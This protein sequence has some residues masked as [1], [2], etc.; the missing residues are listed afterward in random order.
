MP[1]IWMERVS[2]V[3]VSEPDCPGS[4]FCGTLQRQQKRGGGGKG[5]VHTFP[6]GQS[7]SA[8]SVIQPHCLPATLQIE[9]IVLGIS[10]SPSQQL[11]HLS[12]WDML[13]P[14]GGV[15]GGFC[16]VDIRC[17]TARTEDPEMIKL[18]VPQMYSCEL[19]EH[20][21]GECSNPSAVCQKLLRLTDGSL[22]VSQC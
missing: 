3:T 6:G 5:G 7:C 2:S 17:H 13:G 21:L 12:R 22:P 20:D 19:C 14:E 15:R 11:T 18:S 1:L 4:M 8:R 10:N 16:L 9:M